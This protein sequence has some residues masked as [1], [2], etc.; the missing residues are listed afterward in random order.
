[1]KIQNT[2]NDNIRICKNAKQIQSEYK[3][4]TKPIQHQH[5]VQG[6]TSLGWRLIFILMLYSFYIEFVFIL[7]LCICLLCYYIYFVCFYC[8]S[9]LSRQM[10]F[11]SLRKRNPTAV[12]ARR[13][14]HHALG[15]HFSMTARAISVFLP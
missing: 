5:C 3:S 6:G 12:P 14:R 2:Y 7:H 13:I 10:I 8:C 9:A 1:M 4:Y 15:H 11:M